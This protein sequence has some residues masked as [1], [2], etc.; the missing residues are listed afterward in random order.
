M[1]LSAE[2]LGRVAG[3]VSFAAFL[4]YVIAIVRR[5]ARPSIATWWIWTAVGVCLCAS[6]FATG[7][8]T[9]IWTPVSFVLGPFFIAILSLHYGERGAS[10][11]DR[12]CLFAAA[13]SIAIWWMTGVPW[14]ALMLNIGIDALGALPTLRKTWHDPESEDRLTWGL[15][16]IGNTLN[17]LAVSP[18]TVANASYPIYMSLLSAAMNALLWRR[19][20]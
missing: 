16:L 14:L 7:A 15:F 9:T 11:F 5:R 20:K 4:P 17:L 6:Y 3:A 1:N 18:W 19:R 10:R 13:I 2:L 8:R 12:A